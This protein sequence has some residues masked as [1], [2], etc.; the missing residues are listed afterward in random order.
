[1]AD[2]AGLEDND[3]VVEVN[4]RNV[5]QSTHEEV[6]AMIRSSGDSLEMLVAKKSVY[7]QLK[8]KGV[9][10]T[11]LLLGETSEAQVHTANIPVTSMEL[12]REDRSRPETPEPARERVSGVIIMIIIGDNLEIEI[13]VSLRLYLLGDL[14]QI[15][16]RHCRYQG[17]DG[18]SSPKYPYGKVHP[19]QTKRNG[20]KM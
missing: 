10:I 3:I 16:A 5:E 4:G 11:R 17:G 12:R 18:H 15:M 19:R 8:A 7:D 14:T 2:R 20:L 1:M 9:T 13:P 6:V